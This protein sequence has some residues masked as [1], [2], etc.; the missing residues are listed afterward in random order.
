MR[1]ISTR[2]FSQPHAKARDPLTKKLAEDPH[3]LESMSRE[4]ADLTAQVAA[5][6]SA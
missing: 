1:C 2:S 5:L 6:R 3:I 4:I